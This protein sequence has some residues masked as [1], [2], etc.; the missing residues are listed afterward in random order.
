V[1]WDYDQPYP[2]SYLLCGEKLWSWNQGEPAGHVYDLD[3]AQPGLDLLLLAVK[4]LQA[5]YTARAQAAGS[6]TRVQLVPKQTGPDV[7]K[8]AALL[9]DPDGGVRELTYRD[10]EGNRTTFRFA[11]PRALPDTGVFT[12]P[13][14]VHGQRE[15]AAEHG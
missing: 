2:K 10:A 12:P 14:N 15:G 11:N 4:D 1:R 8:D 13:E 6:A 5:R 3:Q 9:V 7:L